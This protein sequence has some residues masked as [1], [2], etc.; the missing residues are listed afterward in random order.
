MPLLNALDRKKQMKKTLVK[1]LSVLAVCVLATSASCLTIVPTFDASIT[2]DP[3]GPA[4]K[5][6][7]NAAIRV[8]QTNI[9][10][11]FTVY[12]H[13]TND[14]SVSLGQSSTWGGDYL[15]SDYLAAL[16]SSAA[17]ANDTNAIS[18]LPNT[19]TDPLIGGTNLHLTMALARHLGLDTG[20][21]P[22]GFDSTIQ[23]NTTLMNFSRPPAISTNYD[24]QGTVAHEMD[25]VLGTSSGLPATNEIWAMDLFRYT[26][27]LVRTFTTNGDNAY[28]SVDGT[29]L[30]AR[31]NTD[32]GG[33]YGD[34]WSVDTFWAPPGLTPHPQVQDAF[35]NPGTIEDLGPNELAMLD[36]VGWT[37]ASPLPI[38][39]PPLWIVTSGAGQVTILWPDS[40]SGYVLQERTNLASGS[41]V[42]SATG[43]TNP[44]AITT[45]S[46]KFYRLY[47]P[48]PTVIPEI[49]RANLAPVQSKRTGP[50]QL[51]TRV[52]SPARP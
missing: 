26:T 23:L 1:L 27:N 49:V 50:L 7:I 35:G 9:A 17:D 44:A 45:T 34:W 22:D 10:D 4:M 21:G 42:A 20:E 11:N 40:F 38:A 8:L 36:A 6:A 47:N 51:V 14:P 48:N 16:K 28:F 33:D 52:F 24:M 46:Q 39:A 12:I 43:P 2:N 3:N 5:A 41:W 30:W 19:P 15:Y 37:L 29:N 18:Q 25:E 13:F 31:F 32:P